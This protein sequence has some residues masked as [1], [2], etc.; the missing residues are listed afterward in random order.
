MTRNS[1]VQMGVRLLLASGQYRTVEGG[2][3]QMDGAFFMVTQS[4]ADGDRLYT[5]LTLRSRDVVM[6]EV[7]RDGAVV[8]V[9]LGAARDSTP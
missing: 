9:V 7:Q 6:A 3:A 8:D 2:G 1:G 4:S 5:V